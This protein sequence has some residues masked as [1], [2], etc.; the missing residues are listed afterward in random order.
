MRDPFTPA[1]RRVRRRE[2]PQCTEDHRGG[3]LWPLPSPSELCGDNQRV[4][5]LIFGHISRPPHA[6]A[7]APRSSMPS[8]QGIG[9]KR[10]G[11][12]K[13]PGLQARR[14]AQR[15]DRA[16]PSSAPVRL[17]RRLDFAAEEP[18][19]RTRART[20]KRGSSGAPM[21]ASG[22]RRSRSSTNRW[23]FRTRTGGMAEAAR[24][25]RSAKRCASLRAR[26]AR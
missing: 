23:A 15:S 1:H 24:W 6:R 26:R 17:L 25:P 9:R 4:P 3:A 5:H 14:E 2:S 21:R 18:R 13:D 16:D 11:G 22:A 20:R 19:A 10:K 8:K 7:R 12:C